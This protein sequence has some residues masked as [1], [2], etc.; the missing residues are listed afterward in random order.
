MLINRIFLDASQLVPTNPD[1]NQNKRTRR[2]HTHIQTDISKLRGP[3]PPP[4][5]PPPLP[6]KDSA[7]APISNSKK[8][9]QGT[10]LS[11]P[12]ITDKSIVFINIFNTHLKNT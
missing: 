3:H 1:P 5:L 4:T 9:E 10:V 8:N 7:K 6:Q 11:R 12:M 2:R